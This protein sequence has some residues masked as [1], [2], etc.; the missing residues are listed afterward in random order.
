ASRAARPGPEWIFP[1]DRSPSDLAHEITRDIIAYG[2][3]FMERLTSVAAMTQEMEHPPHRAIRRMDLAVQYMLGD[4]AED[5]KKLLSEVRPHA[6]DPPTW[7]NKQYEAFLTAF[8]EHFDV[9][10][11]TASW[12]VAAGAAPTPTKLKVRGI[13]AVRNALLAIGR[14]DIAEAATRLSSRQLDQIDD[15]STAL[16]DAMEEKNV[17]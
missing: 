17:T 13:G 15:R 12:P 10:L 14:P 6:Q 7:R 16:F 2:F 5:A 9:D 1:G 8:A 4:R 3:P 11:N